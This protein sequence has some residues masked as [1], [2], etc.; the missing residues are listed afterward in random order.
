MN[1]F[2]IEFLIQIANVN[3]KTIV[4]K[5]TKSVELT[6]QKAKQTHMAYRMQEKSF[7]YI[8]NQIHANRNYRKLPF[9]MQLNTDFVKCDQ[10]FHIMK[11]K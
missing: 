4:V 6:L 2:N 5:G 9:W 10:F 1:I 3:I 7:S 8:S 11:G